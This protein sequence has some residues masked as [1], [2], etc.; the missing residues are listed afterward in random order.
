MI[1][2]RIDNRP[3]VTGYCIQALVVNRRQGLHARFGPE[4]EGIFG[5]GL[6]HIAE[7]GEF[8]R[9]REPVEFPCVLV[10]LYELGLILEEEYLQL[11]GIGIRCGIRQVDG[12]HTFTYVYQ[13]MLERLLFLTV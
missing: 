3:V 1:H 7:R 8:Q 13:G 11:D 12:L 6:H 4:R 5:T 2:W 9:H 10:F